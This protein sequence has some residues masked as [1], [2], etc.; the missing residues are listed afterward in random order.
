MTS[1]HPV[2]RDDATL[3][4]VYQHLAWYL[5]ASAAVDRHFSQ[6]P[7]AHLEELA[8][9][10]A[11]VRRLDGWQV[12]VVHRAVLAGA[13]LHEI[14][15]AF[16]EDVDVVASRWQSWARQQ[17]D[18]WNSYS[19]ADRKAG[20]AIGLDPGEYA[21]VAQAI[22]AEG[23]EKANRPLDRLSPTGGAADDE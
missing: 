13:S 8:R 3:I 20:R 22:Q 15:L 6:D 23:A 11:L 14:A 4:D 16:G 18:L 1:E 7:A 12:I 19:P 10:A 2:T 5:D 17:R 9:V 21:V